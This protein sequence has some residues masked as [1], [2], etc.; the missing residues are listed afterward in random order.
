ML[1]ITCLLILGVHLAVGS[2]RS[3][4]PWRFITRTALLAMASFVAE[5]SCIRLYDFYGYDPR[6]WSVF[7]DRMPLMVMLIW[8]GVILS[9]WE[10]AKL[11]V[12]HRERTRRLVPLVGGALVLADASF[13]EAI[14]VRAGLW[15]WYA[16]GFFGVPPIGVL[17]WAFFA[18]LCMWLFERNDRREYNAAADL[19]VLLPVPLLTH[20]MLLLTWWGAARW[21]SV[22]IA[23]W[24]MVCLVWAVAVPLTLYSVRSRARDRIPIGAYLTRLPAAAFFFVLL[25]LYWS[26]PLAAY[27]LAFVPPFVSL[28]S[29]SRRAL[30]EK[31]RN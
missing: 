15:Q 14:A 22:P 17:G 1:E 10:L 26:A 20:V 4:R 12:G 23:D 21:V 19:A 3:R 5:D 16:P 13:I 11:L 18:A 24:V 25:V 30:R 7:F 27:A 28:G 29:W 6:S 8:P 9:S 31:L 2:M